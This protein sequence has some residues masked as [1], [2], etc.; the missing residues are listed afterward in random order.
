MRSIRPLI[1]RGVDGL[2]I[3]G[4][5]HHHYLF[6]LLHRQK[7]RYVLMWATNPAHVRNAIRELLGRDVLPCFDLR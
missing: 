3:I 1:E 4:S 5:R 6:A 7:V 2:A